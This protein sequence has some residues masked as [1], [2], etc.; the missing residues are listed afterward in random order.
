[1][2]PQTSHD[3]ERLQFPSDNEL[4]ERYNQIETTAVGV[5]ESGN[6]VGNPAVQPGYKDK[7]YAI[8]VDGQIGQSPA[9]EFLGNTIVQLAAADPHFVVNPK[10]SLHITFT[11]VIHKPE[12]RKT[13]TDIEEAQPDEEGKTPKIPPVVAATARDYYKALQERYPS[14]APIN[15][16][17]YKIIPTP[18]A[19]L[20]PKHPEK[21]SIAVVAAFLTGDREDIFRT[22]QVVSTTQVS[23]VHSRG[24]VFLWPPI[25]FDSSKRTSDQ[26]QFI[27]PNQRKQ[28]LE[29]GGEK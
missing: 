5:I 23:Y 14:A 17:L 21:R 28:I 3:S 7:R 2:E 12:G 4:V 22:R 11:E 8:S 9:N 25:P 10:E 15:L 16:Q 24:H 29:K 27:T 1:M 20:D 6:A 13:E 26:A 19:P 18:D